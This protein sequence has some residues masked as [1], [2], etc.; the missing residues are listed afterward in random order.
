MLEAIKMCEEIFRN[1][2]LWSYKDEN[3]FEVHKWWVSD[4]SRFKADY[5]DWSYRYNM[6]K[7]YDRN[8]KRITKAI[9]CFPL[10]NLSK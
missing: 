7:I 9:Q 2:L 10:N 4:V 5:P 6:G 8:S 1:T 3:R